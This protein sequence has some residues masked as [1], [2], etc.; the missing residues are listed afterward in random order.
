M[1]FSR[2]VVGALYNKKK[3]ILSKTRDVATKKKGKKE[4]EKSKRDSETKEKKK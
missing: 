4:L 2:V 1:V 3:H